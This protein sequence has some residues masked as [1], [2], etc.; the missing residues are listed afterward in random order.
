M[1]AASGKKGR[2]FTEP[3]LQLEPEH[4]AI[5]SK[6]AVEVG[7]FQMHMADADARVDR[8]RRQLWFDRDGRAVAVWLMAASLIYYSACS[9]R[10]GEASPNEGRQAKAPSPSSACTNSI[11]IQNTGNSQPPPTA[12]ED[13]AI[14]DMLQRRADQDGKRQERNRARICPENES[15]ASADFASDHEIG[16]SSRDSRC[17]GN[18]RPFRER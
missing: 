3:L 16:E 17:F 5:E 14:A 12:R 2:L 15:D 6:R 7:H 13:P 4:A 1:I 18:S 11:A 9:T 10:F 8:A